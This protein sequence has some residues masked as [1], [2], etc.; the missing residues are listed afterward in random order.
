MPYEGRINIYITINLSLLCLIFNLLRD[1]LVDSENAHI[2]D[3][4][5]HRF[6]WVYFTNRQWSGNLD[7]HVSRL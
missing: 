4:T 5:L 3:H 7:L 2:M 1:A 6:F